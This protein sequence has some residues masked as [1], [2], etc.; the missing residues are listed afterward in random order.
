VTFDCPEGT[1]KSRL[2]HARKLLK[3]QLKQHY[4]GM[5]ILLDQL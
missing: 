4:G 1:V 5:A 2:H 3:A